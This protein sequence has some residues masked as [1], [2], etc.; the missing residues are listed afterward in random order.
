M[1]AWTG[2]GDRPR[3]S[4]HA[5]LIDVSKRLQSGPQ[6]ER[7]TVYADER[8]IVAAGHA[9]HVEALPAV[10][11]EGGDRRG[12]VGV[13]ESG[14]RTAEGRQEFRETPHEHRLIER[15]VLRHA[16]EACGTCVDTLDRSGGGQRRTHEQRPTEG[17]TAERLHRASIV[18]TVEAPPEF[19]CHCT[20]NPPRKR[21]STRCDPVVPL[22]SLGRGL[23]GFPDVAEGG[24]QPR[25]AAVPNAGEVLTVTKRK[26][27][28]A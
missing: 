13:G 26:Q 25:H 3:D 4:D 10:R 12:K 21:D 6:T 28:A 7:P 22:A 18:G 9:H 27:S 1:A 19:P 5:D 11:E 15:A 16:D 24:F 17:Q 8:G 2:P 14:S 20:R 23:G